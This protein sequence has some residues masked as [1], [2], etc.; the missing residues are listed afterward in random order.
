MNV[1]PITFSEDGRLFVALDFFGDALY[2]LDPD[3]VKPPRLITQDLGWLNGID[4]GPDGFL[5]GPIGR[6][7]K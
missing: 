5:Y 1:N 7:E 4:W 3:L 2:E 6:K